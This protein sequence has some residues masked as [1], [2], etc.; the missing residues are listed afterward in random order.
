MLEVQG[1]IS[2]RPHA[3]V[4]NLKLP[5]DSMTVEQDESVIRN[6]NGSTAWQGDGRAQAQGCLHSAEVC[7]RN[8]MCVLYQIADDCIYRHVAERLMR[9]SI[10][11]HLNIPFNVI[12]LQHSQILSN[13]RELSGKILCSSQCLIS[14]LKE[15]IW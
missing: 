4:L 7:H 13:Q 11:F 12:R 8:R 15:I 10:Q 3:H 5:F 2:P 1:G 6:N 14:Y 9:N